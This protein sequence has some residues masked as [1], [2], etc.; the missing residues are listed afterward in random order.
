MG[1]EDE[2]LWTIGA[3]ANS[4]T[5]VELV[6]RAGGV[7]VADVEGVGIYQGKTKN[8]LVV[9]SQGNNTFVILDATAPYQV[10]GAI[11]IDL[12]AEKNI[13]RVSETDGLEVTHAN[14]GGVFTEGM[15]VVQDGHKVMPQAPQNFKYVS[16]EKIRTALMLD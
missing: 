2:A 15:L 6:L 12:S 14:L 7:L 11:R 9:S 5:E 1:E 10:H 13:D 16:W 4:G 8:Y 3:E